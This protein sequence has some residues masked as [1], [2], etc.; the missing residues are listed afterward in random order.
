MSVR[1]RNAVAAAHWLE[2]SKAFTAHSLNVHAFR[3]ECTQGTPEHESLGV[4]IV[5]LNTEAETC[6][7]RSNVCSR[8]VAE[9]DDGRR[10]AVCGNDLR[11]PQRCECTS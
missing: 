4:A 9:C 7:N 5:A 8:I 10:C 1:A 11:P 3:E 6:R 2:R